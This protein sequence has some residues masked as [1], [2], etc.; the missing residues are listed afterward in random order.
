MIKRKII[1]FITRNLLKIISADD[2]LRISEH[3]VV[4]FRGKKLDNAQRATLIQC[5]K[6]LLENQVWQLIVLDI[7]FSINEYIFSKASTTNEIATYRI[8]LWVLEQIQLKV[9]KI[10]SLR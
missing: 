4:Y 10:A 6:D 3:G 7:G 9:Q 2:F 8:G 1:Y 5:A